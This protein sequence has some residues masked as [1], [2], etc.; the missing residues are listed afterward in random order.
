M[1]R[2]HPVTKSSMELLPKQRPHQLLTHCLTTDGLRQTKM[3]S[4]SHF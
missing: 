3:G 1:S 4:S 2:V